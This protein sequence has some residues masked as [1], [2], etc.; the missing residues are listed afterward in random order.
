M[1][2]R[3]MLST[4]IIDS[5]SFLEMPMSSQLLYMHLVLRAD[6]DGFLNNPKKIMRMIGAS[7]D[8]IKLLL[9]KKFVI[10]F[11]SGVIVIKHW[12]IHN[13]IQSDRYNETVYTSE[14]NL[15]ILDEKNIYHLS[16][17]NACI[18]NVYK[19][20]TQVKLSK[21]KTSKDKLSKDKKEEKNHYCENEKIF[22]IPTLDEVKDYFYNH[23]DFEINYYEPYNFYS[24]NQARNWK[25]VKDWHPLADMWHRKFKESQK[26]NDEDVINDVYSKFK[27][28]Y[29]GGDSDE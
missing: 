22:S 13:Y 21:D 3:R 25:G 14:K 20:D 27:A 10:A 7:E 28:M 23:M 29:K 15:L 6:D 1:A 4:Q 17:K 26:T 5:D 9:V 12:R 24:Y 16:E 2:K 11:D 8:D 18:Q 19:M